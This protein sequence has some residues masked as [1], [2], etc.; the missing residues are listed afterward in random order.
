MK[1]LNSAM[2]KLKESRINEDYVEPAKV[3]FRSFKDIIFD[4]ENNVYNYDDLHMQLNSI[5]D[6]DL[7]E[8]CEKYADSCEHSGISA[9]S[10]AQ[11]IADDLLYDRIGTK[12]AISLYCDNCGK[13]IPEEEKDTA[14][15]QQ[16]FPHAVYCK[17]CKSQVMGEAKTYTSNEFLKRDW[18]KLKNDPMV[19]AKEHWS[20]AYYQEVAEY[21][22]ETK[23]ENKLVEDNSEKYFNS[24]QVIYTSNA[25]YTKYFEL[26][27]RMTK[28]QLQ[29]IRSKIVHGELYIMDFITKFGAIEKRAKR[30]L[31]PET[32]VMR[33]NS[34]K[35]EGY[36]RFIKKEAIDKNQLDKYKIASFNE[37]PYGDFKN[38]FTQGRLEDGRTFTICDM[39]VDIYN[40]GYDVIKILDKLASGIPEEE[41]ERLWVEMTDNVDEIHEGDEVADYFLSTTD[42]DYNTDKDD[43][44]EEN[45]ELV[46]DLDLKD[47]KVDNDLVSIVVNGKPYSYKSD[48]LSAEDLLAK[49]KSI[50]KYSPGKAYAWLKKHSNLVTEENILGM[51]TSDEKA[52]RADSI[53][54]GLCSEDKEDPA[55]FGT[56]KPGDLVQIQDVYSNKYFGKY[57]V[58][59]ELSPEESNLKYGSGVIG[60]ELETIEPETFK[61]EKTTSNNYRMKPFKELG[62]DWEP[63]NL[64]LDEN[65]LPVLEKPYYMRWADQSEFYYI[66]SAHPYDNTD[67]STARTTGPDYTK[68]WIVFNPD[69]SKAGTVVGWEEAVKLMKDIDKDLKPNMLYD[70]KEIKTEETFKDF[71]DKNEVSEDEYNLFKEIWKE[72]WTNKPDV[73]NIMAKSS[74][75][76]NGAY[77]AL[78]DTEWANQI[79]EKYNL[80]DY[81]FKSL[82]WNIYLGWESNSMK[83]SNESKEITEDYWDDV[84]NN[85]C[86]RCKKPIEDE[87]DKYIIDGRQVCGDCKIDLELKAEYDD[88]LPNK[89]PEDFS[90]DWTELEEQDQSKIKEL[91]S[92]IEN[93][94]E[95]QQNAKSGMDRSEAYQ[96]EKDAQRELDKEKS[97]PLTESKTIDPEEL[98]K[99]LRKYAH[100]IDG[101]EKK[102]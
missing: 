65:G 28:E 78:L 91:E 33:I 58:I 56:Y 57:K 81:D 69:G 1:D 43:E 70:S 40:R 50:S 8:E 75:N 59:R 99:S 86:S 47:A 64:E 83:W 17:D 63:E 20:D 5:E 25:N 30:E 39:V 7:R 77:Y 66:R 23:T 36:H 14:D 102:Q 98:P 89:S 94:K 76:K 55:R 12:N 92:D 52:A 19:G 62:E 87:N 6:E 34:S 96:D 48:D 31:T 3:E 80:S 18:E 16:S 54:K 100:M 42:K 45:W 67:Y 4:I 32:Y 38:N 88:K 85:L 26:K 93:A 79:K 101:F 37:R 9:S 35:D 68:N 49:Y 53:N 13:A 10:T 74:D 27:E 2:H 84:A 11:S 90:D 61:G 82:M 73:Y 22:K 95:R 41:E 44:I 46:E 51:E 60:Y 97:K 29:D 71:N 24:V 72:F 15:I 21:G